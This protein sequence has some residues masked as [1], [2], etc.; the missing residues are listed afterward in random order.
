MAQFDMEASQTR[1]YC[2][3]KNATLPCG[4]PRSLAAQR[5]LARDDKTTKRTKTLTQI[6]KLA[7]LFLLIAAPFLM[8]TQA[9]ESLGK[10]APSVTMSPPPVT[11]I[12]RGK[13]GAVELQFRVNSGFHIN[14]NTPSAEYLIPTALK[15]DPPTDIVVGKITYP[16]GQEMSFAFAPDEKLSVYSGSFTVSVS[17]R[18]LASV[19]PGKYAFRGELKYQ[20]C[21]NAQCFPPKKLPVTFEVKVV[22]APPTHKGN[23]A[24]SPHVHS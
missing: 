4:S 7:L 17:V 2:V 18:P 9:Q 8:T 1:G 19:L 21:D 16:A 3:A 22:K 5:T 23:P 11:A 10:K 20:A 15:L 14:S 12:P 13:A 24:Q 6:T